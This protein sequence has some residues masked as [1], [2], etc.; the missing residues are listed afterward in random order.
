MLD[1]LE[2]EKRWSRYR[3]KKSLPFFISTII[4]LIVAGTTSYLY[5]FYPDLIKDIA[6][7]KQAVVQNVQSTIE[8]NVSIE[9]A[10]VKTKP[11][12]VAQNI[13][14]PSLTFMY[15]IED[16]L[17]NYTNAKAM[18]LASAAEKKEQQ[19][20]T[21]TKT[22][23]K[24]TATTKKPAVKP[25]K[26]TTTAAK[27]PTKVAKAKEKQ[28]AEKLITMESGP[29]KEVVLVKENAITVQEKPEELF[30]KIAHNQISDDELNSVIK[31][32]EKQ[33]KPALSLFIAKKYY[34][35]GNY[36]EA[37][38]YAL[39]T[40]KINPEIEDSILIFC[41]SLVKLGNKEK[42][43]ATLQAYLQKSYSVQASIL[44]NE[45]QTGKFK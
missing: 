34:E 27:A 40:N 29:V 14:K 7:D 2:L 43:V 30:V 26:Q 42:A 10:P 3:F 6:V 1:V 8:A 19:Q 31:R 20:V 17:I 35:Q 25:K 33:K 21:E 11:A 32:F 9:P 23:R 36:Q 13:L 4:V 22:A 28:P 38:N 24:S 5:I 18:A 16:Q 45:I 37:Y 39:E 41:Q 15:N 12:A 44:L